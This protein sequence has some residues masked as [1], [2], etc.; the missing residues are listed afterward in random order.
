MMGLPNKCF[1]KMACEVIPANEQV[2][3]E[4]IVTIFLS[5]SVQ[6]APWGGVGWWSL[7]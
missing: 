4:C 5:R 6:R 2:L 3:S 7:A 1:L